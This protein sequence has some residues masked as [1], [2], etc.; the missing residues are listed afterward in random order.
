M[1]KFPVSQQEIYLLEHFISLAYFGELRDTWA[2]MVEHVDACLRLYMEHIPSDYR[3][4]QLPEQP[5]VVWGE[6]VLPNFRATLQSLNT[7]FILLSHRDYSGLKYCHGPSNDFRGQREFWS[8]WM[9]EHQ[10]GEYFSLLGRSN[11]LASNIANTDGGYW[12]PTELS[13]RYDLKR[14]AFLELPDH[15]PVYSVSQTISVPSGCKVAKAGIYVPDR[16]GS[17]AQFL[18]PS[19]DEAPLAKILV[20]IRELFFEGKKYDEELVIRE[21]PCAWYLVER[22]SEIDTPAVP[23]T[24]DS[25]TSRTEA[26]QACTRTGYYFTPARADSRRRFISGDIMPDFA[27]GYGT[28]IWQWD[29]KQE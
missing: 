18:S 9:S 22:K 3:S 21:E 29:P 17:C 16:D 24:A 11:A 14:R 4:R 15:W 2:K 6:H 19:H 23:L 26:G 27:T 25:T 13:S 1:N 20:E 8:G 28:T 7:G 12:R 10:R 5:D